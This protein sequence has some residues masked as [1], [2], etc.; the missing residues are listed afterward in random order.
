MPTF[1]IHETKYESQP[2]L[3]T[4]LTFPFFLKILKYFIQVKALLKPEGEFISRPAYLMAENLNIS[5]D[6]KPRLTSFVYFI[7]VGE[8]RFIYMHSNI[9]FLGSILKISTNMEP[10]LHSTKRRKMHST[11]R[12]NTS[13]GTMRST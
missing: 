6:S 13:V 3:F 4:I 1:V 7:Q 2:E 5:I 11:E 10:N 12:R 8:S 9:T